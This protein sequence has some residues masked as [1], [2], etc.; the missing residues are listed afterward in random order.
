MLQSND[1]RTDA[2]RIVAPLIVPAAMPKLEGEHPRIAPVLVVLGRGY[3]LNPLDIAT[4]GVN[5]LGELVAS[6]AT[7]EEAKRRI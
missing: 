4:L 5:R 3:V 6:F 2:E 7:D 1:L